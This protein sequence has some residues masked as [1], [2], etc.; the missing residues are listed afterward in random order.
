MWNLDID[1]LQ[2]VTGKQLYIT[3]RNY[4]KL[5]LEIIIWAPNT[6]LKCYI[7]PKNCLIFLIDFF[8]ICKTLH[9]WNL[10]LSRYIIEIDIC[11]FFRFMNGVFADFKDILTEFLLIILVSS[12]FSS[13]EFSSFMFLMD[14]IVVQSLNFHPSFIIAF[15]YSYQGWDW[16]IVQRLSH[17]HE[18][19][20]SWGFIYQARWKITKN[21]KN[22]LW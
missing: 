10:D 18:F 9:R 11:S 5:K 20:N 3:T 22:R 19:F 12:V 16:Q 15:T 8:S 14:G 4:C 7:S 17:M 13:H 6:A 21:S 2:G 1:L